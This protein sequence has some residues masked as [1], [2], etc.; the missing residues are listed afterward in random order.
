VFVIKWREA[1]GVLC[2]KRIPIRLKGKLYKT[3][4]RPTMTYGSECRKDRAKDTSVAEMRV[5]RWMSGA[6]SVEDEMRENRL[7]RIG[8]VLRRKEIVKEM[9]VVAK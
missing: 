2:D 3:L 7:R 8:H 1:L 5:S 9:Y 6:T 4:G